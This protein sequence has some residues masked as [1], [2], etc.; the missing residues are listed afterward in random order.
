MW[1]RLETENVDEEET[2][3]MK[4]KERKET[5]SYIERFTTS[6]GGVG[7]GWKQGQEGTRRRRRGW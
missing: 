4:K 6:K 1:K 3:K 5:K 7:Q 2:I